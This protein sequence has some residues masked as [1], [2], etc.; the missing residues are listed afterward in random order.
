MRFEYYIEDNKTKIVC[1]TESDEE[2]TGFRA[3]G[4]YPKLE[5]VNNIVEFNYVAKK[6]HPDLI[7][8]LC[9]LCF[10]PYVKNDVTFPFPVSNNF[11]S[12][13]NDTGLW[14]QE[15]INGAYTKTNKINITNVNNNVTPYSGNKISISFGGGVDS[16]ALYSLY[17]DSIV[18]H[19]QTKLP[20]GTIVK[21][22]VIDTINYINDI[23]GTA[24][25]FAN[26]SRRGI[27]KPSG[28]ATW[29]ACTANAV[30]IAQDYNIGVI[31]TGSVLGSGFLSNGKK[32]IKGTTK[33]EQRNKWLVAFERI[34]IPMIPATAGLTEYGNML[35][36]KK[37]KLIDKAVW[38]FLDNGNN[39]HKCWKCFRRDTIINSIIPN[40][41]PDDYWERYNT[42]QIKLKLKERPLYF[43]HILSETLRNLSHIKWLKQ[44]IPYDIENT[45]SWLH[46][47]Y[48][49][50]FN[51]FPDKISIE[52]KELLIRTIEEQFE[53]MNKYNIEVLEN[54]DYTFNPWD[55]IKK[56]YSSLKINE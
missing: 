26:T 39:C 52:K 45:G 38:C 14:L 24:I 4:P 5:M 15:V 16:L 11:A 2:K 35:I 18:V 17:P 43:A 19:E 20:N 54:W 9:I 13:F 12:A 28:W 3:E 44:Y 55:K 40:H 1:F 34:G 48:P 31:L 46:K 29:A 10:Y 42:E 25:S 51:V 32:F 22:N 53:P 23:G 49:D 7:A 37:N 50:N 47:Y 30:L 21:E 56:I 36:L 8:L 41:F 33:P 6:T 27:S